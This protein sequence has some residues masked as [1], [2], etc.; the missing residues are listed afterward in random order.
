[1]ISKSS[2]LLLLI[3]LGCYYPALYDKNAL[4]KRP[5]GQPNTQPAKLDISERQ[6]IDAMCANTP[7]PLE[8]DSYLLGF[9]DKSFKYMTTAVSF[10]Q[11]WSI[12]FV[13][14]VIFVLFS[15]FFYIFVKGYA[16]GSAYGK[17]QDSSWRSQRGANEVYCRLQEEQSR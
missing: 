10:E 4:Q 9:E 6:Q 17:N 11:A 8:L 14:I 3:I 12:A 7:A 13:I 1:M 5:R 15:L 2:L 16:S